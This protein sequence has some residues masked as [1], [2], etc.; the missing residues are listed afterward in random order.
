MIRRRT[1]LTGSSLAAAGVLL[2]TAAQAA[3]TP[4]A[5]SIR[6]ADP[7][8]AALTVGNNA[9]WRAQ[10]EQVVLVTDAEQVVTAVQQSVD[11][12]RRLSVRSGGHCYE[13]FVFHA[14]AQTIVDLSVLDRVGYDP[15][16]RAITVQPGA[17]LLHAY[18]SIFRTWGVTLPGGSCYSV[19]A[20]GHIVGGGYGFLSR[21]HGLTVDHLYAVEVV[22]VDGEGRTRRVVAT[23]E[24]GDP[25]RDLWWAHTGGGGGNFG[26]ITKYWLRSPSGADVLPR[27]PREVLVGGLGIDWSALDA[28]R[29]RRLVDNFGRW[30]ENNSTPGAPASRLSAL[31]SLGHRSSGAVFVLA[32][33]DLAAEPVLRSFWR[34]VLDGVTTTAP[35][36][37][38]RLPWLSAAQLLATNTPVLTS[39]VQRAEHKSAYL[40]RRLRAEQVDAMF[41]HLSSDAY[42]NRDAMVVIFGF[43]GQINAVDPAATAVAQRDS[44]LK[45]LF[46]AFWLDPA[47]DDT[48]VGWVRDVYGE[49]FAA[50]GGVPVPN[51]QADGAYVNYPDTD[52]SD[53]RW[54]RSGV[55]WSTLYYKD[56]YARLRQVKAAYDP[57]NVFRHR[58]SVE[59]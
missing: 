24:P 54:N 35:P 15:A 10:P 26:I 11:R 22:T 45:L 43:G 7:R 18:E 20:G 21:Q 37:P 59:P 42:A 56:N 6:P 33:A 32:Q 51:Q 5:Q 17:T 52:L 30:H 27:P 25:R 13:D 41:A 36:P 46:Q 8:Y 28:D 9:R 44:V 40:R 2:P 38:A 29:F 50:T 49:V 53:P 23:R 39:P 58:Q 31:L 3:G 47:E 4:A 19:G 57:L 48:H 55:P 12:G 1:V 14:E 34:E 16:M